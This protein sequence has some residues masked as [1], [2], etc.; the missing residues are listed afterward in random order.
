VADS[1]KKLERAR[2]EARRFAKDARRLAARDARRLGDARALV[3]AAAEEVD[4]AAQAGEPS[5]L[6]E[7]L[8]ALD[9]LWEAHLARR[10]KP[11]WRELGESALAAVVVAL[12]V[13]AFVVESFQIPT[14]SMAPTLLV[15][16]R[17]FVSK[18]AYAIRLP[19][20]HVRLVELGTPRRGDVIVFENPRDPHKDY[21]KRAVGVAGDV[22]ELRE[23]VL[24]VNGI[25]QPRSPL[26]ELA[27]V[28]KSSDSG[29]TFSDTCR[30][31]RESL[32]KGAL[33]Q[34]VGRLAADAEASWQAAAAEGVAAYEVLQCRRARLDARE[35]PFEVVKPG[36]VFVLGDNR[37]RS[38]DSR[39]DGG[40][41][42]P[43]DHVKGRATL[44]FF[45]RGAGG[46]FPTAAAGVRFDRLF[47]PIE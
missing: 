36:H 15:G 47:K 7:A 1:A 4:A 45:S 2:R 9:G 11:L 25:P 30:R 33:A 27:Y 22:V 13:R 10:A 12:L 18:L 5:R 43:L 14:G 6:S 20:T 19:F 16:D 28:E 46:T 3:D 44:V 23:Q 29:Q 21:V 40:W 42:V 41:Q 37:D 24:Y 38:A 31:Y 35:G 34:P 26:G 32:A 8:R 39:G 17:I